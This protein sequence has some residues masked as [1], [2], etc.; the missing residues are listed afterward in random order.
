MDQIQIKFATSSYCGKIPE[1]VSYYL[2]LCHLQKPYASFYETCQIS[3][4]SRET[5]ILFADIGNIFLIVWTAGIIIQF[6]FT[7]GSH[8]KAP[9]V[10]RHCG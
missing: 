9:D 3:S 5:Y 1:E 4:Q 10:S 7:R 2:L 8:L 6:E